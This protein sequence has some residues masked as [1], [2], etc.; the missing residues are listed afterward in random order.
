M[1]ENTHAFAVGGQPNTGKTHI[2]LTAPK[3][4]AVI[5]CDRPG[6]DVDL[7]GLED[8]GIF[9]YYVD[10]N[11]FRTSALAQV[12]KVRNDIV[13]KKLKTVI[14]DSAS[15]G[16]SMETQKR[17]GS[18]RSSMNIKSYGGVSMNV[19]DVL[20]ALFA[21]KGVH[22]GVTF[23]IK[24]EPIK[25]EKQ[26]VI[27]TKWRPSVMPGVAALLKNYCGLIGYNWKKPRQ[28]GKGNNY[29]TCFLEVMPGRV[30]DCA[31]SP[32]GWG[33]AE[34]ADITAWFKRIE[35]DAEVRRQA[36]R[37]AALGGVK[38]PPEGTIKL[39][40]PEQDQDAP[41]GLDNLE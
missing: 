2:V 15:M 31:K 17:S 30:F 10:G 25:N 34:P 26:E 7:R 39:A 32:E 24:E 29:G 33:M 16:Q 12:A 38:A 5:Y 28:D 22:R 9:V 21:L 14:L 20:D 19:M 3:P 8:I 27:G 40:E 13:P 11:D 6:G 36:V 35:D 4:V 18:N 41:A 1:L 23:H 37:A